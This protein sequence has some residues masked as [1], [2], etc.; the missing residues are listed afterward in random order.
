VSEVLAEVEPDAVTSE[1]SPAQFDYIAAQRDPDVPDLPFDDNP[2]PTQCGIPELWGGSNNI[3]H[4]SG[5]YDGRLYQEEVLLYDSHSRLSIEA[6][7]PHGTQVEIIMIQRNPV[8]DYYKVR[9]PAA[10]ED[11]DEGWIPAPFLSR[12]PVG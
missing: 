8:L 3:A 11:S 12:D 2:D 7:A 6:R 9:I 1:H 4:L 10:P 5:V